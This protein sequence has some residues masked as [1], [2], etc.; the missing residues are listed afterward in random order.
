MPNSTPES[1]SDAG[2]ETVTVSQKGQ[3]TIVK[4]VREAVGIDPGDEVWVSV[5]GDR[6]IIEPVPTLEDLRGIHARE[7]ADPGEILAKSRDLDRQER[8]REDAEMRE[9]LERHGDGA[10]DDPD[11]GDESAVDEA[12]ADPDEAGQDDAD[13]VEPGANGGA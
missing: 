11:E 12:D 1:E 10:T 9:L 5:D 6:V 3:V 7:D 2:P 4:A 13:D 8:E